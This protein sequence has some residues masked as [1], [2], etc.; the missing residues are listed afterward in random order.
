M[1]KLARKM[2]S[3]ALFDVM[4]AAVGILGVAGV[5]LSAGRAVPPI[6]LAESPLMKGGALLGTM[7]AALFLIIQTTRLDQKCADDFLFQ[8]LTKSAFMALM[9]YIVGSA[10]WE[11]VLADNLGNFSQ[12]TTIGIVVLLWS[13][14]Y[15][16]TRW[17]GTGA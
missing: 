9:T 2:Y 7:I 17:R 8:T 10:F 14:T 13:L 16:Y 1:L 12:Q 6:E 3:P 15:F 11:A 4:F 5:M